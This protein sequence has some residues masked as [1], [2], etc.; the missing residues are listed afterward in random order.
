[1]PYV[2][3]SFEETART[4]VPLMRPIF[5][6]YPEASNFYGEERQFL[7]GRDVL[8]APPVFE[9]TD[10]Y[11]VRLPPSQWYDYWSG[12]KHQSTKPIRV[13]QALEV[14]PLYVRGGAIVPHQPVVQHT[15]ETPVGPLE[16]RVYPGE[17]CR[18][19]IY[20]DD[21]RTYAY[22][23]GEYLR[24]NYTCKL[25]PDSLRITLSAYDGPYKPWWRSVRLEV[26]GVEKSPRSVRAGKRQLKGWHYSAAK[27]TASMTLPESSSGLT[28]QLVY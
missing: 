7:F 21:G 3:T 11:E 5:L 18:G 22:T 27:K 4:G 17:D 19:S 9:M 12:A 1:M 10:P 20:L 14:L 6:E 23:R 26:F 13:K 24:V 16:L 8:V 2:Y 15:G 28:I 25:A